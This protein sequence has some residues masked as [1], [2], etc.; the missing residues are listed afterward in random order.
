MVGRMGIAGVLLV[1]GALV[2]WFGSDAIEANNDFCNAC[3]LPGGE[4]LHLAIRDGFDAEPPRTLAGLHNAAD[5][6]GKGSAGAGGVPGRTDDAPGRA[7]RDRAFRCIDCHGGVGLMGR[8]KVKALAAKDALVW[9]GGGFEEPDQMEY[10]LGE[11]DCRQCHPTFRPAVDEQD[12]ALRFHALAVHNADLGVDCV[13]CHTVHDGGD[14]EQM[15]FMNPLLVRVQC[16][17]CH[18]QFQEGTN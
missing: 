13:E 7:A 11:A 16:G 3:H 8:A 12:A 2:G 5:L 15:F 6:R 1:V 14:D 9:L 18:S 10:P 4:V 17:R